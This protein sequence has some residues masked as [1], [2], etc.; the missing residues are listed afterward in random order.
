MR[1]RGDRWH[2]PTPLRGSN[3]QPGTILR[4][5]FVVVRQVAVTGLST[6]YQ[7]FD[8]RSNSYVAIKRLSTAP[9]PGG[10]S[11]ANAIRLFIREALLLRDLDSPQLPHLRVAFRIGGDY[12]V[13]TDFVEG[14]PLNKL[15]DR[16]R[17]TPAAA[18]AI[19]ESLCD[20]VA[21][22]HRHEP[23]LIHADIKPNNI[24]VGPRWRVTLLDFGLARQR[25][26]STLVDEIMGTPPYTPPEQ[27]AGQPLDERSDLYALAKVLDELFAVVRVPSPRWMLARGAAQA[28]ADRFASVNTLR[29][30]LHVARALEAE[31]RWPRPSILIDWG[32]MLGWLALLIA[33]CILYQR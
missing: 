2:Q 32:T 14:T 22:L 26:V 5:R 8:Q 25:G 27:W 23:H 10:L 16:G 4:D 28:P 7:G 30:A 18:W 21:A 15:L 11:R 12:F 6:V 20:A 33:M 13:I 19:A 24:I 31:R 1:V 29:R 9:R 3:L 17:V